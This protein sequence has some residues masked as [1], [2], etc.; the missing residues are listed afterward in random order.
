MSIV[1]A[2]MATQ[3]LHTTVAAGVKKMKVQVK[4]HRYSLDLTFPKGIV[5]MSVDKAARIKS[6]EPGK[7]WIIDKYDKAQVQMNECALSLYELESVAATMATVDAQH[8]IV[9]TGVQEMTVLVKESYD[10]LDLAFFP[11][12][13]SGG[14]NHVNTMLMF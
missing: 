9:A 10:S 12:V 14:P 1:A 3:T 2:R 13:L 5:T 6:N 7:S 8:Y 11:E 4:E